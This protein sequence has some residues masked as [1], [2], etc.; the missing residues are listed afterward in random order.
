MEHVQCYQ[1]DYPR[2]QLVRKE[3]LNL[4]G[5]WEFQEDKEGVGERQGWQNGFTGRKINVPFSAEAPLSGIG[6]E[7]VAGTVWYCRRVTLAADKRVLLHFEGSDYE[8]KVWVNGQCVGIN[9]GAYHRFSFE[10]TDYLVEGENCIV[11]RVRDDA[12]CEHPRGKQRWGEKNFGCWYTPT[13]GIYKTVWLE[14][15]PERYI[16]RLK[17]TPSLT[18]DYAAEFTLTLDAP[19]PQA[20]AQIAVSFRGK[21]VKEFSVCFSDLNETVRVSLNSKNVDFKVALWSP[22]DPALYDVKIDLFLGGKRIDTVGSYFGLRE[23]KIRGN[24]VLL[25]KVPLYL[26]FVLDQGYWKDGILTPSSESAL[27]ADVRLAKSLGFNGVRKHEKTEDERF[28][29]Y[30]DVLGLLVW[31][32]MPSSYLFTDE[33]VS[34][35]LSEWKEV[36]KQYHNHPSI[37]CWVALNESW[38][39]GNMESAVRQQE[40]AKALYATAKS[41]DGTRPVVTNDGWE[42]GASDILTLHDYTQSAA[43]LERKV[44]TLQLAAEGAPFN[45]ARQ[46]YADGFS[47]AGQPVMFSEFGGIAFEKE[48]DKGWGYGTAVQNEEEYLARL[49]SLVHTFS[50]KDYCCGWCYTQLTDVQNEVNGLADENR[51][52]K[53]DEKRL[54]AIFSGADQ[55]K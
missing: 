48:K 50:Q 40:F 37:M 15:V 14:Y 42:H 20:M 5:K 13:T 1:K 41:L 55:K 36:V 17:I 18:D 27:E 8:T 33:S 12:L 45:A 22:E 19:C 10:I 29:Y 26:R 16:R 52:L 24:K 2:P 51:V 25:N 21:P 35:A 32:E 23:I 44:A 46:A 53:T 47:Y 4:N 31:C 39:T 6:D 11:V 38:G 7:H 49:A 43:E 28:L 30:C 9:A 54:Q 3:W 34:A